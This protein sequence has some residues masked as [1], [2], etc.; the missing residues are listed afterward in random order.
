MELNIEIA[1]KN[2]KF[3]KF[4]FIYDFDYYKTKYRYLKIKIYYILYYLIE[5]YE[6]FIYIINNL[7]YF[8]FN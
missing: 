7:F 4:I 3:K 5:I 1:I 2:L 8:C 6:K